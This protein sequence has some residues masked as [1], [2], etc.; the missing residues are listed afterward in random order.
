MDHLLLR[1][2]L[3]A[4]PDQVGIPHLHLV[5]R[6]LLLLPHPRNL[7]C[8]RVRQHTNIPCRDRWISRV[9]PGA[10]NIIG[11]RI[12]LHRQWR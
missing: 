2:D 4:N 9:W 10:L 6:R 12:D 8:R 5:G 11:Q 3:W 7:R 1:V